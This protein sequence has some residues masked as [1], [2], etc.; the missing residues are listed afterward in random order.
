MTGFLGITTFVMIKK[1]NA[2]LLIDIHHQDSVN[3][4]SKSLIHDRSF[5]HRIYFQLNLPISL[6]TSAVSY[7]ISH[8]LSKLDF[9]KDPIVLARVKTLIKM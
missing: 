3:T 6:L 9:S 4:F 7:F 2:T 8:K 5:C 1:I